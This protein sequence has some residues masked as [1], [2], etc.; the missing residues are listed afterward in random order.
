MGGPGEGEGWGFA[1]R[2]V[3][4]SSRRGKHARESS[5]D[6][7][8]VRPL[9]Y[10]LPRPTPH[11]LQ[12]EFIALRHSKG[13]G[14]QEEGAVGVHLLAKRVALAPHVYRLGGLE[15]RQLLAP[16]KPGEKRGARV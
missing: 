15:G 1:A 4:Q 5:T 7:P 13:R 14:L 11:V 8:A 9:S 6:T 10:S 2:D 3:R 12:A 16:R